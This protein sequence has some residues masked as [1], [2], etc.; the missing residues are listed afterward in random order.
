MN[1]ITTVTGEVR[2]EELGMVLSHEH[3]FIDLR[4]Q[5][6]ADAS[7]RPLTAADRPALMCDP[8]M[9]LDNLVLDDFA[10]AE[11]EC[12]MLAEQGC[13]TVVDCSTV[14]IGRDPAK[15]RELSLRTGTK[16]VMGCGNYTGDTH[17]E[18]FRTGDEG[19]L[20][21]RLTEEIDNGVGGVR[22]GIIGEIGTSREILDTELKALRIAARAQRHSGLA[23]QVHVYPWST[24]GLAALEVLEAVGVPPDRIVIC[25]SDVTPDRR[26]IRDLLNA[27]VYVQLDN[28]GKEFTPRAG[29]FAAG[30]FAKDSER[31]ELAAWIIDSGFGNRLLL[32]NDV[33]L[34]CMLFSRGG[35]GYRHI[36][37]DIVP[38]IAS[39]GVPE[40][41][42][43][44]RILHDNPVEMLGRRP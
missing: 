15:L 25:H 8:Y 10:A 17:G 21:E 24:N 40:D 13:D 39:L 12:R 18:A 2:P 19:R 38:M 5:A 1:P 42:L 11:A 22:P 9:L 34:K 3:L 6:P 29:G 14:E 32:T 36:F 30:A 4:H 16:I 23:I 44:G 27:G 43:R 37:A 41:Y 26:Y 20:A 35:A 31:A 7:K 33:C 28:F